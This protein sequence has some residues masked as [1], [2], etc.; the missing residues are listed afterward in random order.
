MTDYAYGINAIRDGHR[1]A[2]SIG[3]LLQID[4]GKFTSHGFTSTQ[5]SLWQ[6]AHKIF[7]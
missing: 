2:N 1:G 7:Q 4:L 3:V 6:G 5:P